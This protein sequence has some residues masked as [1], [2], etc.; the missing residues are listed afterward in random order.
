[1]I[2]FYL[3]FLFISAIIFIL[4]RK[5]SLLL[6]LCMSVA[7][8]VGLSLIATFL[9]LKNIDTPPPD[10]VTVYP[11]EAIETPKDADNEIDR[12]SIDD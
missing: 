3:L 10:A 2:L 7:I 12:H 8:F 6:R 4:S 5:L 11:R 1:M 9:L